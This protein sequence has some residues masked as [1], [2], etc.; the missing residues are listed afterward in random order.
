VFNFFFNCSS[1]NLHT[2][3]LHLK[4]NILCLQLTAKKIWDAEDNKEDKFISDGMWR[5]T[6]WSTNAGK[7][8]FVN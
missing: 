2:K 1:S 4:I 5:N 7:L 6:T 3:T 8:S